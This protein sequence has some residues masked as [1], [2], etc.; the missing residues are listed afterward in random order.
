VRIAGYTSA[1][2]YGRPIIQRI[3][4]PSAP[5]VSLEDMKHHLRV[6]GGDDDLYIAGLTKAAQTY[7]EDH[8][9]ISITHQ[10]WRVRFDHLPDT[11]YLELPRRPLVLASGGTAAG[12]VVLYVNGQRPTADWLSVSSGN[13]L[14]IAPRR[15]VSGDTGE[16]QPSPVLTVTEYDDQGEIVETAWNPTDH[17]F[18]SWDA[19]PP[20]ISLESSPPMAGSYGLTVEFTAG[21]GPDHKTTPEGLAVAIKM[22]VGNWFLTREANAGIG[23]PVAFG[24]DMLLREFDAGEYR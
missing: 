10:R 16:E 23:G 14:I 20:L 12:D 3:G 9:R 8:C 5:A 11:T 15:H 22:L 21:Y 19:N 1:P 7:C 6:D 24:C 2:A 4:K 13:Y 17:H 18:K